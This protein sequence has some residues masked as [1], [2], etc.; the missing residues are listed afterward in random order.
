MSV[1]C[2]I[3]QALKYTTDENKIPHWSCEQDAWL[4][5]GYYFWD[6]SINRAHWWG[7]SRY[8]NN[9]LICQSAYDKNFH[10]F[11]FFDSNHR[12]EF[13]DTRIVLEKEF[14]RRKISKKLILA[15]DV[16]NALKSISDFMDNYFAVRMLAVDCAPITAKIIFNTNSPAYFDEDPPVQLCIWDKRFFKEEV[17]VVF[18][19]DSEWVF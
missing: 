12:Q 4:G 1:L 19:D 11:D 17:K 3:Y 15:Q 9:Y 5:Y 16:I 14:A 8:K 2:T 18:P 10:L 13:T 6:A 7:K